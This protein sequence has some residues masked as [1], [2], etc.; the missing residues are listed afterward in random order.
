MKSKNLGNRKNGDKNKGKESLTRMGLG[1]EFL[2]HLHF[3]TAW[4]RSSTRAS[5][6]LTRMAQWPVA[7]AC[8]SIACRWRLGSGCQPLMRSRSLDDWWTWVGSAIL[9]NEHR[10]WRI[11]A[12]ACGHVDLGWCTG[13]P[14]STG[15]WAYKFRGLRHR[16]RRLTLKPI[17]ASKCNR[18]EESGG[19]TSSPRRI[20]AAGRGVD[21]DWAYGGGRVPNFASGGVNRSSGDGVSGNSSPDIYRR[22]GTIVGATVLASPFCG[23][24]EGGRKGTGRWSTC[25]R[26]RLK[27][28]YLFTPE[29][30]DHWSVYQR[31]R[32]GL[33]IPLVWADQ[34][35]WSAGMRPELDRWVTLRACN[36]GHRIV[37]PRLRFDRTPST[38]AN[39]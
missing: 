11:V 30:P 16:R 15:A 10:G 23:G 4:P 24:R 20:R 31:S 33:G 36:L 38:S 25:E 1:N 6:A 32:F 2:A 26:V 27:R 37:I 7:R 9:S 13:T 18:G 28:W 12:G 22:R 3:Y 19:R 35:R 21:C 8:L 17:R 34:N 5:L 14:R 29:N 39:C